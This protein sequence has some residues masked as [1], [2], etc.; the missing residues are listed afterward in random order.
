MI[1]C[2]VEGLVSAKE[3]AESASLA[4]LSDWKVPRFR[5]VEARKGSEEM[6]YTQSQKQVVN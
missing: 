3:L 4:D 2:A 5:F 6:R 1:L